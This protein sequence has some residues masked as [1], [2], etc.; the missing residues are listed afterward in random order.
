MTA[1]GYR[2]TPARILNIGRVTVTLTP[3]KHAIII[4]AV[5]LAASASAASASCFADYKAKRD[6]PLQLHYGVMEIADAAC[7]SR[8]AAA[9]AVASRLEA[10]GWT[11][12]NVLGVFD[13][14]GL[15][16]RKANAGQYFLRF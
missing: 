4:S 14:S 3:M 12:L 5:C 1:V 13:Q 2:I 6:N 9:T 7:G 15:E 11:L 10:Q 16:E 8:T